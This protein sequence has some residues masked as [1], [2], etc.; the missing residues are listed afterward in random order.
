MTLT[1]DGAGSLVE[2]WAARPPTAAVGVLV[3]NTTLDHARAGGD[4]PLDR[5]VTVPVDGLPARSTSCGELR[6]DSE[7]NNLVARWRAMGGV[8]DWPDEGQW[9]GLAGRRTGWRNW[10]RPAGW[11]PP[12]GPSS[13]PSPCPFPVVCPPNG[14]GTLK[15]LT[16]P[17]AESAYIRSPST[18]SPSGPGC[19]SRR[20]RGHCAI[21]VSWPSADA[22]AGR[23]GR[24][25]AELHAQPARPVARRGPARGERHRVPRPDRAL[26]TPRC[27]SA[28][29]RRPPSW[30][31]AC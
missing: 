5:R 3:W 2:A 30:A 6:V 22:G 18:P 20:C 11:R 14:M 9:R 16:G 26:T 13:S 23:G 12:A 1:G 8:A 28:T 25:R 24:R 17:A 27:C 29:R 21:P 15:P 10:S 19:R 4:P 7:H 31:A